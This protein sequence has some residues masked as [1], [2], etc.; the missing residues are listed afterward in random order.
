MSFRHWSAMM[1]LFALG[2]KAKQ[3]NEDF[4]PPED[5]ARQSLDRY[6]SAWHAGD[7]S[8][9]ISDAAPA[10]SIADT[11]RAN[12][13]P[14]ESFSVLGPTP[15]EMPRCYAV[16]LTLGNPREEIRERYIVVGIDPIWIIRHDDYE[17]VT[18]WCDPKQQDSKAGDSSKSTGAPRP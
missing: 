7:T 12:G 18:H 11:L 17:K 4:I 10:V 5:T 15:S 2:C 9:T 14:L 8:D 1:L 6:L 3:R 16:K 13:R